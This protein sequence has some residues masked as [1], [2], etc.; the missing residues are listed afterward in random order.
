MILDSTVNMAKGEVPTR[1][2]LRRRAIV[3]T[4]RKAFLRGGYG[5]TTMSSIAAAIGGSKTT[6]WSYFR[7]KEDLFAAVI[8]D[9]VE[10]YGE[11]LRLPLPPDGDPAQTLLALGESLMRTIL[12]PEIVAMHR[13]VTG[14]AGR[15]PELG[16]TLFERGIRRGQARTSEWIAQ[17]MASG[18]LREDDPQRAAQQFLALCQSGCY[19]QHILGVCGR[20]SGEAVRADLEG[21]V[22]TFMR[23]Y[24]V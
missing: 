3:A 19:Q 9:L 14:E 12:R 11:A 5:Q 16:R 17:Q 13:L 8:D 23:A 2:D 22:A 6:L 4:A 15:S 1:Q 18:Q 24:A 20:P 10:R 7:N 21:A